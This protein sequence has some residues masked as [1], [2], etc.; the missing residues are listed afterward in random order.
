MKN[1]HLGKAM[2]F[3]GIKY[4]MLLAISI[5][6]TSTSWAQPTEQ[7]SELTFEDVSAA[8]LTL[9]VTKG[10]GEQRAIFALE[11]SSGTA[12]PVDG[13]SYVANATYGFGTQI[14]ASGWFCVANGSDSVITVTGL[15]P[16]TTYRFMAVEYNGASGEELYLTTSGSNNPANQSMGELNPPEVE[17]TSFKVT[18]TTSYSADFSWVNGSGSGRIILMKETTDTTVAPAPENYT[19]YTPDNKFT[20]GAEVGTGWFCVYRGTTAKTSVD[21]L[22][23]NTTYRVAIIDYEGSSNNE[24][25]NASY[26]AENILSFTTKTLEPPTKIST[27][28]FYYLRPDAIG[29]RSFSGGDGEKKVVF[30]TAQADNEITLQDS[31]TYT[32]HPTLGEGSEINGWYCVANAE[33]NKSGSPLSYMNGLTADSA[34]RM[35]IFDYNGLAGKE[36]YL[37]TQTEDK[38]I[39]T[40]RTGKYAPGKQVTNLEVSS[41]GTTAQLSWSPGN[42]EKTIVFIKEDPGSSM[43]PTNY[44]DYA[45]PY[46]CL[47]EIKEEWLEVYMG[48]DSTLS[49]SDLAY[50]TSYRILAFSYNNGSYAKTYNTSLTTDGNLVNFT[51]P[52]FSGTISET[53]PTLTIAAYAT[54]MDLKISG[55]CASNMVWIKATNSTSDLPALSDGTVYTANTDFGSG[56]QV[57]GWYCVYKGKR[58][59]DKY[60]YLDNYIEVNGLTKNTEY[61]VY[62]CAYVNETA[63]NTQYRNILSSG[64]A[65]ND[66]TLDNV[67]L[68]QSATADGW[69]PPTIP[70][71]GSDINV[72][73]GSFNSA[74]TVKNVTLYTDASLVSG[75]ALT[76]DGE[77]VGNDY[78]FYF[79]GDEPTL[80]TDS[81]GVSA[82]YRKYITSAAWEPFS[83]PFTDEFSSKS[84]TF[85][86]KTYDESIA[87]DWKYGK[88]LAPGQGAIV[89]STSGRSTYFSGTLN[90]ASTPVSLTFTPGHAFTGFNLLGNPFSAN[91]DWDHESW[92]KTAL[93]DSY[94]LYKPSVGNYASYNGSVGTLGANQYIPPTASFWVKTTQARSLTLPKEARTHEAPGFKAANSSFTPLVRVKAE[95]N[96]Y[97]DETIL[98]FTADAALGLDS[99]DAEKF[100]GTLHAPQ[101]YTV[102]GAEDLSLNYLPESLLAGAQSIPLY[103]TCTKGGDYSLS[104]ENA[105]NNEELELWLHDALL[106]S[107]TAIT[108][109]ISYNFAYTT[110]DADKRFSLVW[111]PKSTETAALSSEVESPRVFSHKQE[112]Y[113]YNP[114]SDSQNSLHIYNLAGQKIQV[115]TNLAEG[116]NSFTLNREGFYVVV[117]STPQQQVSQKVILTY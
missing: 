86:L 28:S 93:N 1:K 31:V 78:D 117:F 55:N 65:Q 112:I 57:D 105:L 90:V 4:V 34:Y 101:L 63:G 100:G 22:S 97:S 44:T 50:E 73:G 72:K 87:Q 26:T 94:W 21:S 30:I 40:F 3:P 20:L 109:S 83:T 91:L 70:A 111:S 49:L 96:N 6:I 61:R 92:D 25:Y 114:T 51:T 29:I 104:L 88:T 17:T 107:N 42:G 99:Y 82:T 71:A 67:L 108:G 98:A 37:H 48:S 27:P 64:N 47:A 15:V 56:S 79:Y 103:F 68:G 89:Y 45:Y 38:N 41:D 58:M 46:S 53:N 115:Y 74:M 11:G 39:K 16:N 43:A 52:A 19:F 76:I 24:V 106:N 32:A 33:L 54:R 12:A 110:D 2:R 69:D 62:A 23:E 35:A 66:K 10:D 8:Q 81:T 95:A 18:D 14:E 113:V 13:L 85:Y 9:R 102:S 80:I 5:G 116:L 75:A 60:W 59:T 36:R 84:T 7:A 77:V